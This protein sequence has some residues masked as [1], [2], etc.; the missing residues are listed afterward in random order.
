ML[1]IGSGSGNHSRVFKK[2]RWH[3]SSVD[4]E[5]DNKYSH[6]HYRADIRECEWVSS[7]SFD[8]IL[9]HNTLCHVK[10]PPFHKIHGWLAVCGMFLCVCPASGTWKG[11]AYGKKYTMFHAED[12]LRDDLKMFRDVEI[13]SST[14]PDFKGH[15]I[16]SWVAWGW[17]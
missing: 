8:L 17:K 3:V 9:D 1:D 12:G 5:H 16:K 6:C 11:V 15:E 13:W 4:I 14:Y 2:E 10:V 7:E